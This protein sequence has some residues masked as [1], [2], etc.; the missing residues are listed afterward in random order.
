MSMAVPVSAWEMVSRRGEAEKQS[1]AVSLW[2]LGLTGRAL[3]TQK[4]L[5]SVMGWFITD[6]EI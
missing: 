1:G 3:L 5:V 2:C 6:L 4:E